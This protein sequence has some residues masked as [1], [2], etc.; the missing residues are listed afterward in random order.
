MNLKGITLSATIIFCLSS[1]VFSQS[2]WNLEKCVSYALEKNINIKQQELYAKSYELNR[3]QSI[4]NLLPSLSASGAYSSSYG[5]ALDQT[6][7]QFTNNQSVNSLNASLSSNLTVFSGLQKINTIQQ[8]QYYL[9][10]SLKDL[11]KLKNDI[12]LNVAA[13][14]L[15]ILF[16]QELVQVSKNQS[17]S[18]SKKNGKLVIGGSSKTMLT[19]DQ[20]QKIQQKLTEIR[21]SFINAQ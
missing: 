11:E 17:G 20:F 7:Y 8:N 1:M 3:M 18:T 6:T 10:A 21:N 15:Q 19:K 9:L 4:L 14:Y 5:R 13:A 12:S 2:G 16:N